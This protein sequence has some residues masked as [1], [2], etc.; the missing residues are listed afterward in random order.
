MTIGVRPEHLLHPIAGA[1]RQIARSVKSLVASA[2]DGLCRFVTV[3]TFHL[4]EPI[5]KESRQRQSMTLR[6]FSSD[7]R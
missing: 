2:Q 1:K 6:R 7:V 3:M 5:E 4:G